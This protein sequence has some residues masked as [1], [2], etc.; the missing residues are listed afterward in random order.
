MTVDFPPN[1]KT[2]G[3]QLHPPADWLTLRT[4]IATHPSKTPGKGAALALA[5]AE[6]AR[7]RRAYPEQED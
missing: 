4:L 7:A 6:L 1:C 5:D 2:C 3:W